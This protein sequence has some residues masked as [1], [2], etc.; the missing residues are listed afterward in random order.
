MAFQLTFCSGSEKGRTV[1]LTSGQTVVLGRGEDCDVQVADPRASRVHCRLEVADDSVVL[2]D[3]GSTWGTKLN[4]SPVKQQRLK[5]GDMIELGETQIRLVSGSD[6]KKTLPPAATKP[7]KSGGAKATVLDKLIGT[8]L[9]RYTVGTPIDSGR[10]GVVF[11]AV[12]TKY[13]RPVALKVL[14][15]ELTQDEREVERFVR[16]IKTMLPLQHEN[17]VRL[18]GAGVTDGYCWMAMELVEGESLADVIKRIGVGGML[19][20]ESVLRAAAQIAQALEVAF[21]QKIVHRNI[22]PSNVLIRSKDRV[23]KLADLMLAKALE[24]PMAQSITRAGELVGELP[25]MSPEQTTGQTDL[26]CRSDIYNLG[27][28]CYRMLT[29]HTPA[30]GKNAADTIRKIQNEAPANP[31][32][33]Q[34]AVPGLFEGVVMKTLAKNRDDRFANPTLLLK[35]LK[36]VAKFQGLSDV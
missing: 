24:G 15:P 10:S 36:R 35:D 5:S 33:F 4:G 9:V 14:W 25:Y 20:W 29:G 7:A 18:Y 16:A 2:I 30:E 31:T 22:T 12:D 34:L 8:T 19:D 6:A 28:T 3:A 27:A 13:D 23:A 26:D 32:K 1:D 21:E 17:I 11:R